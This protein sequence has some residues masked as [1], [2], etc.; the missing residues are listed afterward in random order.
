MNYHIPVVRSK[1]SFAMREG[2]AIRRC[3]DGAKGAGYFSEKEGLEYFLSASNSTYS[4]VVFPLEF[5]DSLCKMIR[6]RSLT[7]KNI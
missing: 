2:S 7:K 4:T 1:Y 3:R 6:S 5:S